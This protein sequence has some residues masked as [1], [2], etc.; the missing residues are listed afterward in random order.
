LTCFRQSLSPP[1]ITEKSQWHILQCT[2]ESRLPASNSGHSVPYLGKNFCKWG[3]FFATNAL[4]SVAVFRLGIVGR[5]QWIFI[6]LFIVNFNNNTTSHWIVSCIS[7][8]IHITHALHSV[9]TRSHTPVGQRSD[10][11]PPPPEKHSSSEAGC[12]RR[13]GWAYPVPNSL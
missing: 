1:C 6:N 10:L 3:G 13:C 12:F 11:S 5:C 2:N 4:S 8:G 9:C 7:D